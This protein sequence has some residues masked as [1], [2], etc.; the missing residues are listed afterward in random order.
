MNDQQALTRAG[1]FW[2]LVPVGLIVAM[3]GGLGTMTYLAT[4]DPSFAVEKDY[5]K[6]AV[7]WDDTRAQAEAN[8]RLG[9]KIELA[10]QP[11]GADLQV[12]AKV[13][14]A[15][16]VPIR[17]ASVDLEAF[18]NARASRV[19]TTTLVPAADASYRGDVALTQPGLWEFRFKVE[20]GGQRFTGVVRQEVK[21][22]DAS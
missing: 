4:D 1:R 6:K 18:A 7:A 15:Q 10:T 19:H 22:G 14:D 11:H 12:V 2:S 20:S 16:G 3:L 8:A 17:G 13:T 21:K 9:W 5:Y